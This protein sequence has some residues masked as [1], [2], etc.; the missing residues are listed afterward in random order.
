[1][2][3]GG[4]VLILTWDGPRAKL[5]AWDRGLCLAHVSELFSQKYIYSI[6]KIEQVSFRA[7]NSFAAGYGAGSVVVNC[8]SHCIF[9]HA[10]AG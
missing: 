2:D 7:S 8:S 10:L 4:H 5:P 6:N 9:F 1:M 3:Y